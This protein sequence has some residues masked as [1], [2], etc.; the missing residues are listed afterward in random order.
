M[1]SR[2]PDLFAVLT[3]EVTPAAVRQAAQVHYVPFS[4]DPEMSTLCAPILSASERERAD[5]F[6][7]EG[8]RALF[9]QRRAFRRYCG[10]TATGSSR[11][12]A[13][14]L[15]EETP[16][17]RPFLRGSPD[18]VFSFSSCRFGMLGAWSSTHCIGV[19]VEDPT[20]K[21]EVA[22]LARQYFS[23]AEAQA[24]EEVP[25]RNRLQTFYLFWS[26]KEAALKSVGEGLPFGLDAFAF[27]LD[28]TPRVVAAPKEF[29]EPGRFTAMTGFELT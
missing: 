19:D 21:L 8:E 26:L 16:N 20:K 5:R 23:F 2:I 17:G 13:E 22:D 14:I 7:A 9:L 10:A 6:A 24:I 11:P 12:L 25:R 29:G 15:F 4:Q 27:E 18:L 1:I 28:P 3:H